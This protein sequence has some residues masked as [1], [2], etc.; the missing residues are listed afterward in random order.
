[1]FRFGSSLRTLGKAVTLQTPVQFDSRLVERLLAEHRELNARYARLV[2]QIGSDPELVER[3]VRECTTQLVELR[4]AEAMWLYP[5]IARAIEGDSDAHQQFLQLRLVMLRL[6]RHI[7]RLFDDLVQAIR[8][9]IGVNAA[10]DLIA[11]SL[12]EYWQRNQAQIYPLYD[13]VGS[14]RTSTAKLQAG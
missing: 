6:A 11:E 8:L 13:L 2:A 4:R 12:A 14:K 10:A 5:V 7:L 1:M 3:S 9:N